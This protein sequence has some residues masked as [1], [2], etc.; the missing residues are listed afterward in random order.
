LWQ[1]WPGWD[2]RSTNGPL[3]LNAADH[4]DWLDNDPAAD[5]S[6]RAEKL[7]S[8]NGEKRLE[9]HARIGRLRSNAETLSFIVFRSSGVVD[10]DNYALTSINT[11]RYNALPPGCGIIESQAT[12]TVDF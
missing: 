6:V 8:Q 5:T 9:L 2:A 12:V 4:F 3:I 1:P 11:V 10:I 7:F